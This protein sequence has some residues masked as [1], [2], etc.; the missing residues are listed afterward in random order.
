M[1]HHMKQTRYFSRP[2]IPVVAILLMIMLFIGCGFTSTAAYANDNASNDKTIT[3]GTKRDEGVG[4][5]QHTTEQPAT[6]DIGIG[7]RSARTDNNRLQ[8]LLNTTNASEED[9]IDFST[10][11]AVQGA[12][13]TISEQTINDYVA[14]FRNSQQLLEETA[15]IEWLHTNEYSI[16]AVREDV[17][18]FYLRDILLHQAAEEHGITVSE[19]EIN[20]SLELIRIQFDSDEEF[21]DALIENGFID[22]QDYIDTV[23]EPSLVESKLA[24]AVADEIED[25]EATDDDAFVA[26]FEAYCSEQ[27]YEITAAPDN[28]PYDIRT[29]RRNIIA[30]EAQ[31][32]DSSINTKNGT[33]Y[34]GKPLDIVSGTTFYDGFATVQLSNGNYYVI[35][36]SGTVHSEVPRSLNFFD[37]VASFGNYLIDVDGNILASPETTGYTGLLSSFVEGY[38]LAY[39]YEEVYPTSVIEV[40]VLNSDGEWEYELSENSPVIEGLVALANYIETDEW[41]KNA[42]KVIKT[43]SPSALVISDSWSLNYAA[44]LTPPETNCDMSIWY[45]SDGLGGYFTFLYRDNTS[46]DNDNLYLFDFSPQ[47]NTVFDVYEMSATDFLEKFGA[48]TDHYRKSSLSDVYEGFSD[49]TNGSYTFKIILSED[50]EDRPYGIV[51]DNNGNTISKPLSLTSYETEE[52]TVQPCVDMTDSFFV[53]YN[54]ATETF[55]LYNFEGDT[56]GAIDY[57]APDGFTVFSNE[58]AVIR[59]KEDEIIYLSKDGGDPITNIT[60][61]ERVPNTGLTYDP[62]LVN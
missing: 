17:I 19:D 28:L 62:E 23:I 29:P 11:V 18:D 53:L 43:A 48:R 9:P 42:V 1:Q 32:A 39:R 22:E 34:Q 15:W 56:I 57:I 8:N 36:T 14:N 16:E 47:D 24:E 12:G 26:W 10:L 38:A 27:N 61:P 50:G 37:G 45:T 35:D 5:S 30:Y 40:G 7:T 2:N 52:L 6:T 58:Y 13:F 20:E 55:E 44:T 33:S 41:G 59:T 49:M 25:L 54:N 3:I 31:S 51:I 60:V 4:I 46:S 21:Y